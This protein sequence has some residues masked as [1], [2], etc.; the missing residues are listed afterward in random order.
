MKLHA[1]GSAMVLALAAAAPSAARA[2]VHSGDLVRVWPAGQQRQEGVVVAAEADS[3]RLAVFRSDTMALAW[4]EVRRIDVAGGREPTGQAMRRGLVR[5]AMYG[6]VAGA[7]IGFAFGDSFCQE[8]PTLVPGSSGS[9]EARSCGGGGRMIGAGVG[10]VSLGAIGGGLGVVYGAWNPR[11][12]WKRSRAQ[13]E[14][15]VGAAPGG[16]TVAVNLRF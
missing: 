13:P 10:A 9:G 5:G 6:A 4:T 15:A 3:L 14:V 7:V 12:R 2:Q 8:Q 16:M 1:Y 11:T